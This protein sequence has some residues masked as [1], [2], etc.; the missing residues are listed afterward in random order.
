MQQ[1]RQTHPDSKFRL[2]AFDERDIADLHRLLEKLRGHQPANDEEQGPK[3]E[4]DLAAGNREQAR[5]L[6]ESRKRRVAIFGPH[7]FAEPAWDMLLVLYLN[8]GGARHTHTSLS[9]QSGATRSTAM[10]WIDFLTHRNLIRRDEHPTDK[11]R[12]F[13]SLSDKGRAMLDLY[14][15]ETG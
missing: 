15:S 1:K 5:Q 10:R 11:R 8:E 2:V 3:H 7:M 6:L 13:L 14:L 4:S 9:E 12:Y